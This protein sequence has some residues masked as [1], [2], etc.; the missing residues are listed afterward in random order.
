LLVLVIL[1]IFDEHIIMDQN[2]KPEERELIKLVNY[3]K[4]RVEILIIG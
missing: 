4:K 2:L 1:I 3:F